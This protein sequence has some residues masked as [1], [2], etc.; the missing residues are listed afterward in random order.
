MMSDEQ[1]LQ[2][3]LLGEFRLLDR[4]DTSPGLRLR[5]QQLLTYLILHRHS[6]QP[7]RRIAAALWPDA[8]DGQARTNL[9]KE[10]HHLRQTCPL[11]EQLVT[12]TNQA[13]HWQPRIPCR[14][15]IEAFEVAVAA[16]ADATG[17]SAIQTLE[18][19]LSCYRDDLWPDCDAEWIYPERER[20]RQLYVRALA[21]TTRLLEALGETGKAITLGQRW[22]EA[23]PLD[24]GGYQAMMRLHGELGDRA[25]A[26]QLYHHG[27]TELQ[28]EL[29]V[30]PSAATTELYQR[31]LMA[32]D[33][34]SHPTDT[35]I[36]QAPLPSDAA[37]L[38][39]APPLS[40][41][42]P[43]I[44]LV[45]RDDLCHTLGQ[46]LSPPPSLAMAEKATPLLLLTGEPGIGKTRLLEALS[47]RATGHHH[48]ACW[49]QVFAAEQLR[50]YGV[51][52]D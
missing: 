46:W 5:S 48:R 44:P 39:A 31:L 8:L 17:Q 22:L 28:R 47:D 43:A 33:Q 16:A 36:V 23:A 40:L 42:T 51:W 9:R 15:D 21:Q 2:V 32:D 3:Y 35:S 18:T 41:P 25:T 38:P 52:I 6:P 10:L 24:E 29:G 19:A 7:R 45:G 4:G 30:S 50:S 14:L 26:L 34:P 12:I 11:L 27:M 13:L 20:L 49:G 37:H 1:H